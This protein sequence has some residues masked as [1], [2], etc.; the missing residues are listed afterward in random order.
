MQLPG[1]EAAAVVVVA[2]GAFRATA[3]RKPPGV[4][5]SPWAFVPEGPF[6]RG[7][8]RRI[9]S[10]EFS[11]RLA[12]LGGV[13]GRRGYAREL[14]KRRRCAGGR[15]APAWRPRAAQPLNCART[16]FG[17]RRNSADKE[18]T[19]DQLCPRVVDAAREPG[20][21]DGHGVRARRGGLGDQLAPRVVDCVP[22]GG[23]CR[24]ANCAGEGLYVV[25]A[26]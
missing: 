23:R 19:G 24:T 3:P 18:V 17:S 10:V 20:E 15:A 13:G 6:G 2:L 11:P 25:G 7:P 21:A 5:C 8:A 9:Y 1:V 22:A 12:R 26:L 14:Q 4:F 16:W